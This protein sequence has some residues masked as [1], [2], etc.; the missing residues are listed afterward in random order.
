MRGLG[1]LNGNT[2]LLLLG[3]EATITKKKKKKKKKYKAQNREGSN[4][5]KHTALNEWKVVVWLHNPDPRK[6]ELFD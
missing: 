5:G 4:D 3:S 1:V 2:L 6:V